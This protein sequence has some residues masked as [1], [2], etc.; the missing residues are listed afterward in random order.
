M[1]YTKANNVQDVEKDFKVYSK[2]EHIN[3][4]FCI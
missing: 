3:T 1:D 2:Y 4:Y